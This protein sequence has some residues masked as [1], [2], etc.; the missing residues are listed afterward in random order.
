MRS[1]EN[2]GRVSRGSLASPAPAI[3]VDMTTGAPRVLLTATVATR[4]TSTNS[5]RSPGRCTVSMNRR[6]TRAATPPIRSDTTISWAKAMTPW[7]PSEASAAS[8]TGRPR[9]NSTAEARLS[10]AVADSRWSVKRPRAARWAITA[11]RVVGEV[12]SAM[13]ASR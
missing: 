12:D 1:A 8:T 7:P 4:T 13:A 6:M 3:S 9:P 5:S 11:T 2:I 10:S